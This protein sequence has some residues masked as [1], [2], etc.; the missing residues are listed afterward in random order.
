MTALYKYTSLNNRKIGDILDVN[1]ST[2]SQGRKRLRE[3]T[4]KDKKISLLLDRTDRGLSKIKIYS[5][6]ATSAPA[7]QKAKKAL[8][9]RA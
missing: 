6:P 2:V 1:Y 4:D 5:S 3:Q 9:L 8:R 7:V